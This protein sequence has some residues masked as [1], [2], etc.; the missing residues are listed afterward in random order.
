M[1]EQGKE[2]SGG[3]KYVVM[4]SILKTPIGSRRERSKPDNTVARASFYIIDIMSQKYSRTAHEFSCALQRFYSLSWLDSSSADSMFSPPTESSF[5][6]LSVPLACC[7]KD[8]RYSCA[9]RRFSSSE[10]L[11]TVTTCC[12]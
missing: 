7:C 12:A 4:R 10:R 11:S 3:E 6:S 8:A 9:R 2:V 1:F 5:C